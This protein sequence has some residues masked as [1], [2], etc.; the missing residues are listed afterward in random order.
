MNVK[1]INVK[2]DVEN[3]EWLTCE[4]GNTPDS[5]GFDTCLADGKLIE[6]N[7]NSEWD[8]HYKCVRCKRVYKVL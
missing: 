1:V 3:G 5:D 2:I 6:P 7:I 4:C 8:S